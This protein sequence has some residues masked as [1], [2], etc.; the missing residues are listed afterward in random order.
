MRATNDGGSSSKSCEYIYIYII[1]ILLGR[2]GKK[3]G[4]REREDMREKREGE[5]VSV[6]VAELVYLYFLLLS[7]PSLPPPFLVIHTNPHTQ[8]AGCS[9]TN[10]GSISSF[11]GQAG[12]AT[13]STTKSAI[14]AL[15]RCTAIDCGPYGIRV[16]AICPGPILTDATRKHAESQVCGCVCV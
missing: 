9:I 13:Y 3:E 15:T 4:E 16:N 2:G 6:C 8:S 12:M 1:Y 7:P 11:I 14:L 5:R 10:L